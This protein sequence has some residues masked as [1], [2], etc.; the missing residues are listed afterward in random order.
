MATGDTSLYQSGFSAPALST[1]SNSSRG[2]IPVRAIAMAGRK[3]SARQRDTVEMFNMLKCRLAGRQAVLFRRAVRRGAELKH[4]SCCCLLAKRPP[5]EAGGPAFLAFD[6]TIRDLAQNIRKFLH[7]FT[8]WN[9]SKHAHK[10]C[11]HTQSNSQIEMHR[12]ARSVSRSVS[13]SRSLSRARL[14]T[15][16]HTLKKCEPVPK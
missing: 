4:A 1:L 5:S 13:I 3:C 14:L 12:H 10:T 11:T 15:L 16:A 9:N 7:V 8:H 6:K 2:N